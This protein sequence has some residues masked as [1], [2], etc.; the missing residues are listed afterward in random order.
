MKMA[1]ILNY[2]YGFDSMHFRCLVKAK[3]YYE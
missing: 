1:I 3:L 2:I